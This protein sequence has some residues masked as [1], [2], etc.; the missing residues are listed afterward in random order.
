VA[1]LQVRDTKGQLAP[2]SHPQKYPDSV[3]KPVKPTS[4]IDPQ[5]QW[6]KRGLNKNFSPSNQSASLWSHKF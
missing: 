5:F 2:A 1:T 3:K 6:K 4:A